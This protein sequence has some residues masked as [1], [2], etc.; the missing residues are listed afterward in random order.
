MLKILIPRAVIK[1]PSKELTLPEPY[2]L[3]A[4][5]NQLSHPAAKDMQ[6]IGTAKNKAALASSFMPMA[7]DKGGKGKALTVRPR[8]MLRPQQ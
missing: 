4:S 7:R 8:L 6:A 1:N 3:L 5:F 2:P